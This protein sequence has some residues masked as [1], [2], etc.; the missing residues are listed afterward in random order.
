V[1]APLLRLPYIRNDSQPSKNKRMRRLIPWILFLSLWTPAVHAAENDRDA[2]VREQS[3]HGWV[4]EVLLKPENIRLTAKMDT[5]ATTSSLNALNKE[6]F[7]RDGEEWI[8]FDIVNPEDENDT[9]RLERRIVR[10]VRIIRHEGE[11]QRRPVVSMGIC[12]GEH[13]READVSLID[14][15]ELTHQALIGRNHMKG[16]ILVDSG[17]KNLQ[18]PRCGD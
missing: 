7:E 14:R 9:K 3:I 5:G 15:T 17:Q 1:S 8:A 6:I 16:I 11:H 12:M 13:Y 2:Q 4:E 10:Y 18:P